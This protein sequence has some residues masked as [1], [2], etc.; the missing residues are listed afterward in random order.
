VEEATAGMVGEEEVQAR[1]DAAGGKNGAAIGVF[2]DFTWSRNEYIDN[3][4]DGLSG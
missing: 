4:W 1:V 2:F 3:F